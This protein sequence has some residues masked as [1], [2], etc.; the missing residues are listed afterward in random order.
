MVLFSMSQRYPKTVDESSKLL[1]LQKCIKTNGFN[2][3]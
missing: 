1:P 3:L 2:F